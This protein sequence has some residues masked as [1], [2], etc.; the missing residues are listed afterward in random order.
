MPRFPTS[1]P[2]GFAL[3]PWLFPPP[4]ARSASVP[5]QHR[6]LALHS[7]AWGLPVSIAMVYR[8]GMDVRLRVTVQCCR[9]QRKVTFHHAILMPGDEEL[10]P[11]NLDSLRNLDAFIRRKLAA[12]EGEGA[13]AAM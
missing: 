6:S 13:A 11:E 10:L 5:V 2:A 1:F 9:C 8:P 12:G 4:T 7:R 3:L